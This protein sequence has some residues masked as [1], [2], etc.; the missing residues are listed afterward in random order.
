MLDGGRGRAIQASYFRI[1]RVNLGESMEG[2]PKHT[3]LAQIFVADSDAVF[4]QAVKAGAKALSPMTSVFFARPR[5][6]EAAANAYRAAAAR[7]SRASPSD[8]PRTSDRFAFHGW[9]GNMA[10]Q[11]SFVG[12]EREALDRGTAL[13]RTP[14]PQGTTLRPNVDAPFWLA[15]QRPSA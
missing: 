14:S 9:L 2:W 10:L 13:S 12:R 3:L 1:D 7:C 6:P 15:T 11:P 8:C 5:S 4:A